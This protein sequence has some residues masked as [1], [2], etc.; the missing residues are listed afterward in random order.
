MGKKIIRGIEWLLLDFE[1]RMVT[2]MVW[3]CWALGI[4][5]DEVEAYRERQ[6]GATGPA[7]IAHKPRFPP[8]PQMPSKTAAHHNSKE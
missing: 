6:K 2:F 4:T 3:L 8:E 7:P 1:E 5:T